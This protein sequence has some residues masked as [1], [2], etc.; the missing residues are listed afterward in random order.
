MCAKCLEYI[1]T[2][3]ELEKDNMILK[4]KIESSDELIVS[5]SEVVTEAIDTMKSW[6]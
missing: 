4:S 5:I 1:K 3:K 2:I 6:K